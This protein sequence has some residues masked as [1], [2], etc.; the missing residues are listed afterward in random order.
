VVGRVN[1]QPKQKNGSQRANF[2][3]GKIK[4]QEKFLDAE[5]LKARLTNVKAFK[6]S[7]VRFEIR[8][9]DRPNSK[10]LYV[11]FYGASSK[12]KTLRVSDHYVATTE[13]AQFLIDAGMPISKKKNAQFE[14]M[15]KNCIVR[16]KDYLIERNFRKM[17]DK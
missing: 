14:K 4:M 9:S 7:G 6:G 1:L 13:H 12:G 3:Q 8:R 10:T 11:E 16:T 2:R 17:L 5:Y 15:V